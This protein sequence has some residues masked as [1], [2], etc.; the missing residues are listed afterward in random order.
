MEEIK[1]YYPTLWDK[2]DHFRTEMM[3]GNITKV[4]NQGKEEGLFVDYPTQIIMNVLVVSVREVV[5][6]D[7]ILKNN[8]SIITA[9]RY[10]LKIIIGGILTSK[11]KKEFNKIFNKVIK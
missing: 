7:F 9:A 1:R 2:I 6:P 5:N 8:F 4:I 3:F 10:A 11:G